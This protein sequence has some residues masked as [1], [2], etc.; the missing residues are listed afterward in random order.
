MGFVVL[1]YFLKKKLRFSVLP[2]VVVI[3]SCSIQIN[4]MLR[5]HHDVG[6]AK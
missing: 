1:F 3:I 2:V 5:R 4:L 6:L